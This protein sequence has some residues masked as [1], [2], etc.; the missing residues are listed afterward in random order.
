MAITQLPFTDNALLSKCRIFDI[1]Y[2]THC[3]RAFSPYYKVLDSHYFLHPHPNTLNT[4]QAIL[5]T[6][7][8]NPPPPRFFFRNYTSNQIIT[9]TGQINPSQYVP[10]PPDLPPLTRP[11]EPP[12]RLNPPALRSW[13]PA[14]SAICPCFLTLS[15]D[16]YMRLAPGMCADALSLYIYQGHATA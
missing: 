14:S 10:P 4:P 3:R 9:T 2:T 8:S 7:E 13:S 1:L 15:T 5:C 6:P 12:P 11:C 16:S